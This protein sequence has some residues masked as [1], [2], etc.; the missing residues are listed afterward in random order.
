MGWK[1]KQWGWSQ[2]MGVEPSNGGGAK[3]WGWS[4]AM[5]VEPSNERSKLL[6]HSQ[7][8]LFSPNKA[9]YVTQTVHEC[10]W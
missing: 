3:Q 9:C 5:G 10:V 8:E 2:A 4:Q 6:K 7:L 1:N